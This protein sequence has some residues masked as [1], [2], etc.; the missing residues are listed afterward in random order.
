MAIQIQFAVVAMCSHFSKVQCSSAVHS[1][2][3]NDTTYYSHWSLSSFSCSSFFFNCSRS[4]HWPNVIHRNHFGLGIRGLPRRSC[5]WPT[6]TGCLLS[7]TVSKGRVTTPSTFSSLISVP[8]KSIHSHSKVSSP[9]VISTAI[10]SIGG[11]RL[12]AAINPSFSARTVTPE[13]TAPKNEPTAQQLPEDRL[14][15]QAKVFRHEA[16][17]KGVDNR[18]EVGEQVRH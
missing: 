17:D 12:G 6:R 4:R 1:S 3:S 16:V 11:V 15:V 9:V 7:K 8:L 2:R 13:T 14:K 18:V 10:R 5:T